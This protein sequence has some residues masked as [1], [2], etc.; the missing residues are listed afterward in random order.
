MI[1]G[2]VHGLARGLFV[3]GISA[4]GKST[5]VKPLL[6]NGLVRVGT[7]DVWRQVPPDS[8]AARLAA[9]FRFE[10]DQDE[11]DY[12][13]GST[14]DSLWA[15]IREQSVA[16]WPHVVE[17]AKQH[18]ADGQSVVLEGINMLPSLIVPELGFSGLMLCA[19][20][21]LTIAERLVARPRWSK[22]PE[23][24]RREADL[25]YRWVQPALAAEA[26]RYG[27]PTTADPVLAAATLQQLL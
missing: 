19:P 10:S 15:D 21:A 13:D 14:A 8:A 6:G 1:G 25:L 5:L 7:D 4:A 3:T 26:E 22:L 27:V 9:R 20:D 18:V 16:L 23:L 11:A 12:L 2:S 17:V 24:Q